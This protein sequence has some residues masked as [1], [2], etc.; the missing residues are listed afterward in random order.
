MGNKNVA[1]LTSSVWAYDL[2]AVASVPRDSLKRGCRLSFLEETTPTLVA[3]LVSRVCLLSWAFSSLS[4]FWYSAKLGSWLRCFFW[5]LP[6]QV[7]CHLPLLSRVQESLDWK[8]VIDCALLLIHVSVLQSWCRFLS[9]LM[10]FIKP[11][12][13]FIPTRFVHLT[14]ESPSESVL[15][16][17][18]LSCY[19]INLLQY[20][21]CTSFFLLAQL[22]CSIL[23]AHSPCQISSL[24]ILLLHC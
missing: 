19:A 15:L 6:S 3:R 24:F 21:C 20:T 4:I 8:S 2:V 5:H 9:I 12:Q 22:S 7:Y 10:K 23:V 16:P 11:Y 17:L 18:N 13:S 14:L 1:K